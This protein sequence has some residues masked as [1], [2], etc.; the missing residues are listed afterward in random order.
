MNKFLV[1]CSWKAKTYDHMVAKS[2]YA[3]LHKDSAKSDSHLKAILKGPYHIYRIIEVHHNYLN[4]FAIALLNKQLKNYQYL[5]HSN[6]LSKQVMHT[7]HKQEK[8][9]KKNTIIVPAVVLA[10]SDVLSRYVR[11]LQMCIMLSTCLLM[12]IS[13]CNQTSSNLAC[14]TFDTK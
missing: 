2:Y 14:K 11:W 7:E 10:F 9:K 1:L 8:N 13:A 6:I 3:Y 5:L 12:P 4:K